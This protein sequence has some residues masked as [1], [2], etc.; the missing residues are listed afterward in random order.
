MEQSNF[1]ITRS[2]LFNY[3]VIIG[4]QVKEP[5]VTDL[6]QGHVL[7]IVL[8]ALLHVAGT[9]AVDEGTALLG[10]PITCNKQTAQQQLTEKHTL[11]KIESL[12][13]RC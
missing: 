8:L 2:L 3:S 4:K 6:K 11:Y 13:E 7:A 12:K 10:V 9:A 1:I 5:H